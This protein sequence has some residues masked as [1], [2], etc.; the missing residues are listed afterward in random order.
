MDFRI[1]A[2]PGGDIVFHHSHGSTGTATD[3]LPID[4]LL[5]PNQEI[6]LAPVD[7]RSSD[8]TLPFFNLEWPGGGVVG[9]I[10][11]TGQWS[12]RVHRDT[13]S[14]LTLQAGQQ[15]THLSLRPGERIRT[16]RLLL[17]AWRGSDRMHGHN[18]FRRLL[19]RHYLPRI[20]GELPI[21][22]LTQNTWFTYTA[23]GITELNQLEVIR[24]AATLGVECYWLD[25]GWFE[26]GWPNGA[27][28]WTPRRE[29]FP[30][31]LAPLAKAAHAKG[32]KFVLW[33]E[34][35]R[36]C[37]GSRIAREHPDW[38]M[39]VPPGQQIT[40]IQN[41]GEN[42][43]FKL[44]DPKAR[45][46]MTDLLSQGIK[47]WEVDIYRQDFNIFGALRF[48][49][50]ADAPDR[51]GMAE[52][53][54]IQGLY[55]MWDDLL[56]RHPRLIIDNCASGGRRIDLETLS[57][58]L[59]L[60]RSDSQCVGRPMPVQD[61]V[62]TAGLSLYVPLHAAA[63]WS[64]DPYEWRSGATTGANLCMDHRAANFN[65]AAARRILQE[66]MN[67]RPLWLGDYYPLTA[68][69]LDPSQWCA[70]QFDR[71]DLGKGFAMYFRRPNS[72]YVT[73]ESG[74]RALDPKAIYEVALLD[75]NKKK[76]LT[77]KELATMPITIRKAPESLLLTYQRAK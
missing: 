26:G 45:A 69:N 51:Q 15:S 24:S 29:A 27:G 41:L 22:P 64:F 63:V 36:V 11:W 8:T 38:V 5:A 71:P 1:K 14:T 76:S 59:P 50:A 42:E 20:N 54:H 33:F 47:D 66:T 75:S 31:G 49:Q 32:M 28:S 16:P 53:L 58:S 6:R 19:R 3:F 68:I 9:T 55:A 62:Q 52:N 18:Q 48:W 40:P 39:H 73:L 7:G 35:E 4:D 2:P 57:R 60:W 56:K 44:G 43:L 21:P 65:K 70:W 25:A 72:K 37:P 23:N 17:L 30:R 67:L 74:L 10:G 34:P 77:G 12:M 46:W 13:G 61:Q